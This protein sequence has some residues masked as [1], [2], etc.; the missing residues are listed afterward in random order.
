MDRLESHFVNERNIHQLYY[1][2]ASFTPKGEDL[3]LARCKSA[4]YQAYTATMTKEGLGK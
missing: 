1:V 3:K 4:T 2:N